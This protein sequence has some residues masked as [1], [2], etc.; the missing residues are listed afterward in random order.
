MAWTDERVKLLTTL[1]GDGYSASQ[2]AKELGGVTRNA[3]IGK[4]HRLGQSTRA[5]SKSAG[6]KKR[7]QARRTPMPGKTCATTQTGNETAA[8]AQM[9][10]NQRAKLAQIIPADK[11]L[12]P[13]TSANEVSPEALASHREVMKKALRLSL[14]ELPEKTCKWPIGD[15]SADDFGFCGLPV[16]QGKR[17]CAACAKIA[18]QPASA[19]RDRRR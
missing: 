7:K 9:T 5:A 11:P 14:M 12:P 17:Y 16:E 10:T 1:W 15:P 6:A 13:Q 19:R 3:V 4:A 8:S 2:I 18:Y